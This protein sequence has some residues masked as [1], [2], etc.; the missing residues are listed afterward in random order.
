[1]GKNCTKIYKIKQ[2]NGKKD[3]KKYQKITCFEFRNF[4]QII[5]IYKN[6][7]STYNIHRGKKFNLQITRMIFLT[8][9]IYNIFILY[10]YKCYEQNISVQ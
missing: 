6:I 7:L 4:Q 3:P 5:L 2:I 1:M 8:H 10:I 9:L